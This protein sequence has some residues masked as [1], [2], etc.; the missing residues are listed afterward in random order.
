MMTWWADYLGTLKADNGWT[1]IAAS[2]GA[3]TAT[4]ATL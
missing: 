3:A 2:D 4:V 1:A